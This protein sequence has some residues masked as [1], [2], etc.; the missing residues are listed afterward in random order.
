VLIE[1]DGRTD[2]F[3]VAP[4]W[5]S[6]QREKKLENMMEEKVSNVKEISYKSQ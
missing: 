5:H 6:M 3:L 2:S 4:R 1:L